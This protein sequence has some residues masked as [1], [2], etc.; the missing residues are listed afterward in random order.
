M[1]VPLAAHKLH[2]GPAVSKTTKAQSKI[3]A[4]KNEPVWW[5]DAKLPDYPALQANVT[6]DVCIVGAGISGLTTAYLLAREG[7]SVVVLDDG[8]IAGGMTG[9]TTA[10]LATELDDRYFE[11]E[12]LRGEDGSRLAAESHSAAIDRI[13]AIVA[14]EKID[15]DFER[16]DGFLFLAPGDGRETL[17]RELAAAHRAGLKDVKWVERAPLSFETG[18]C[19][20]FPRQGQFHP[21]K[22]LGGLAKAFV[23]LGGRIFLKTHADQIEGG[24]SARVAAGK[25]EVTAGAVVVATN[26]PINDKV[27]IHTKQAPYMTYAIGALVPPGSVKVGLYWD[28]DD[29]YHYVRLQRLEGGKGK[30]GYDCLI[31]GGEDHKTGQADDVLE[32]HERLESWARERF[33]MIERV[34]FTWGGQVMDSFDG[35]A[36]IG[37]NPMDKENVYIVTGDSG[38]GMTHGTIAGILLTDLIAGRKNP[39]TELYEPSRKVLGSAREFAKETLNVAAQYGDWLTAGDVESTREIERDSGAVVRRGL[40]KFAVYR[41]SSGKLHKRSAVCPHLGCLVHWNGAEKTWD[42][43]CHGS[44]FDKLGKVFNGPA[45]TDLAPAD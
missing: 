36:F 20:R 45:N 38:M 18:A 31:V 39:W 23:R 4:P 12:R 27:I 44:R 14:E 7:R 6:A 28:T 37:R 35:L 2:L 29:P 22:Y 34:A 16:L 17:E 9:A 32:R 24:D 42:C 25:F 11:I 43:P 21:L 15:C 13:E 33:P 3:P 26:S 5:T 1:G 41:D 40:A 8:P 10:H 30:A 19:L